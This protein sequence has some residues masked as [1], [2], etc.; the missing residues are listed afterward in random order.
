MKRILSFLLITLLFI[1]PIRPVEANMPY[2]RLSDDVFA[3]VLSVI[4]GDALR[5]QPVGTNHQALVRLA[6]IT[7]GGRRDARDFMSGALLGR[8]VEVILSDAHSN[9]N[10]DDRWVSAYILH[11]NVVY[12]RALVQRG[13]A[14]ID[15]NYQGHWFYESFVSD[16]E[17]AQFNRLGTWEDTGFR[18]QTVRR[19]LRSRGGG[20]HWE[21]RVNINTAT[22]SQI[23][24]ILD[25]RSRV[26]NDIVSFRRQSPFQN[27]AEIKFAD[28][29]SRREFDDL[30]GALKVST[31]INTASEEELAQLFDVSLS[32]ARAIVRFRQQR[33]F[34]SIY[35]LRD[36]NLM[37]LSAFEQ[38]R[39]F[40]SIDYVDEIT[41]AYPDIIVNVNTATASQL[42]QAGLSIT[43]ANAVVDARVNGYTIKN[44]GE[45]Q[46]M[47]GVRLSD[48]RLHEI[49]DNIRVD[50]T[51]QDIWHWRTDRININTANRNDLWSVGFNEV[52]IA[53][54]LR[55]RGHMYSAHDI[56]FDISEF[57]QVVT[58]FT[59]INT[60]TER[61]LRSLTPAIS[62]S[63]ARDLAEEA[64]H[65]P[66][67]TWTELRDFFDDHGYLDIYRQ[68]YRFLVL[69]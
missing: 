12:N 44:I 14:T 33:W 8:T 19:R 30:W 39:P 68:I 49:A 25:T 43:Q 66:F 24:R 15:P 41:A 40:I 62:D 55:N 10:L 53:E 28:V 46:H 1:C 48:S 32:D 59:N 16:V 18:T 58:L 60:A 21:E 64:W 37:S 20:G 7:T 3:V 69:R 23:N 50:T 36:E 61:E 5:V 51:G 6:G 29:L 56:P 2:V 9:G 13:L 35:Q 52:Q 11:N 17:R 57:N 27:I 31:N 26:G 67:G 63:F 45:L 65:Q 42:Q 4:D 38:N 34:H 54:L 22:A 47:P